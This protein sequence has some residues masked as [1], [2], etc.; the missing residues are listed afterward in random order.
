MATAF[1]TLSKILIM[2][3]RG[4]LVFVLSRFAAVRSVSAGTDV[5]THLG[6]DGTEIVVLATNP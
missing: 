3:F 6:P 2:P 5:W 1:E 4:L